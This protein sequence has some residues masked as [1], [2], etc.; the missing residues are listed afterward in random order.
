MDKRYDFD[1]P[2]N[3]IGSV[4]YKWD[5]EGKG[6]SLIPLGVADTD[7]RAPEPVRRAVEAKAA[8]GVYGYGAFPKERF[9]S[10]V[11]GWYQRRYGLMISPEAVCPAQGIMPGAL[12][13]LLLSLT[14]PG[15]TVLIQAPVYHNFRIV[16]ENMGRKVLSSDLLLREGRYEMDWADLAEKASRPEVRA[17]L[18]CSPH[19]PVG[20][21][22]TREELA[23]LCQ[24]C[25][26]NHVLIL[27]DEIHGDIVY[28][29]HSHTPILAIPGAAEFCAVMSGPAKTFNLAGFYSAYVV[30]PNAAMRQAYER[31]YEQFHFD[32]NFMGMEALIA[33]YDACEDFV[34]QQNRYFTE[35]LSVVR[36][37]LRREMPEL[38]LIEPE[39]TYLLWLDCRAWGLKQPELMARFAGWGVG[40][41]DGSMYGPGGE[42]FVRMNI[43]T[44]RAV[45]AEALG[46]IKTGYAKWKK[47]GGA[48]AARQ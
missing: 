38:R 40:L 47:N 1:E 23:R 26:Q 16:T 35:N 42:G 48:D 30:I 39:G 32:Y 29:G 24:I 21:V 37:F 2:V 44:R 13:M 12:W 22:W 34:E 18:L 11:A 5:V 17:L 33:A 28:P 6:G 41:N 27:S 3:R 10:A 45:L 46:R 8:F 19:N 7:F 25:A 43:A 31:V 14:E 15:D 9:Q 20:R 4:S 36:D